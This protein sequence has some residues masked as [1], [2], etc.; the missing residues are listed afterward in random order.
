MFKSREG[1][2]HLCQN[3]V[4]APRHFFRARAAGLYAGPLMQAVHRFKYHGDTHLAAPLGRLLFQTFREHFAMDPVDLILPVPLHRRK[5]KQ[6]G[7][8][9]SF[10]LVRNWEKSAWAMDGERRSFSIARNELVRVRATSP[11]TGLGRNHRLANIRNAFQIAEPD[12]IKGKRIL[13]VDDVYT[14]GATVDECARVLLKHQARQ[15]D[16]LTLARAMTL[17]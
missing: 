7:F 4:A 12:K 8:N 1:E 15:V 13:L 14:T 10:L 2:D 6:R 16:V 11:Q 3:C 9:Q 17:S 5:F